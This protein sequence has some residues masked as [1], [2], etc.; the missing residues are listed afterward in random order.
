[1]VIDRIIG[2]CQSLA[3]QGVSILV[4]EQNLDLAQK[5]A[6]RVYILVNGQMV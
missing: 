1:M 3:Q 4:A 5:I 2:I 6:D